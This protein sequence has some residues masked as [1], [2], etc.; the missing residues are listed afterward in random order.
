MADVKLIAFGHVKAALTLT[1]EGV[2]VEEGMRSTVR[3]W[4]REAERI[5]R[6]NASGRPGPRVITGKYRSSIRANYRY[7]R[8]FDATVTSDAPQANR[9]EYGFVGEDSL[10]RHYNQP[11]FPHFRP[12]QQQIERDFPAAIEKAIAN[13]LRL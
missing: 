13:A 11:P 3:A 7:G 8:G 12:A 4:G 9:L 5:V 6:Q 10:G 1:A 2:A